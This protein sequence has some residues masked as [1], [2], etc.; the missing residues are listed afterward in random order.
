MSIT[1]SDRSVRYRAE[2]AGNTDDVR[3]ALA[4]RH[5]VFAEEMGARLHSRTPGLDDEELDDFCD[6]LVVRDTRSD[7]IVACSRLL[8]DTQAAR[9]GRYYSESEFDLDRVLALPGRFLEIGRTCVDPGERGGLVM[10]SLWTGLADYVSRGGF[11]Y[12]MGCASIPPG[13]G[14]FA[15]D[16]LC[17]NIAAH[18]FG[19]ADLAVI[20]KRQV[21]RWRRCD[22]D[23]S[24]G[25]PLLQAYLRLG[26]WV[27]GDPYWDEDFDCMDVFILLDLARLQQ[28]YEKRFMT[29]RADATAARE[30]GRVAGISPVRTRGVI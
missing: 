27:W 11:S 1:F 18:R 28:R 26:C 19:P 22:R 21:P 7:R 15:I 10:S 24:G 14:G 30:F 9:Y 5:R 16:A 23:E 13:P 17:R 20:S 8:T 2:I 25:P 4:L 6:H 3:A 29:L 12:L